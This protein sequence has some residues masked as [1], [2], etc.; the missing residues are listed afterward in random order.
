MAHRDVRA[1]AWKRAGHDVPVVDAVAWLQAELC[2][3]RFD[4]ES[5][6]EQRERQAVYIRRLE[7][8]VFERTSKSASAQLRDR[9]P[10]IP[11]RSCTRR[12]VIA[13]IVRFADADDST[14]AARCGCARRHQTHASLIRAGLKAALAREAIAPPTAGTRLLHGS[15]RPEANPLGLTET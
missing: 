5:S 3:E 6:R 7:P 1:N 11:S 9:R 10:D 2:G 15:T 13:I 8:G 14:P 12:S 4:I